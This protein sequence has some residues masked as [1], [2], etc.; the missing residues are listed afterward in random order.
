[1]KKFIKK[2]II[3]TLPL[4]LLLLLLLSLIVSYNVWLDPFGI[5]NADMKNQLTEPN[6]NYLKTTH[7]INNPTKYNAF[8]F[9]SS[10]AGK[11]DVSKIIDD[12][13]SKEIINF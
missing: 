7:I 8:L 4:L 6:Q 2:T 10:R 12:N 11:I 3:F 13:K 5:I 1:M 9:G